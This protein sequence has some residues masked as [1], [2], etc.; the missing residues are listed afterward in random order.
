MLDS[1][2]ATSLT[3]PPTSIR[4]TSGRAPPSSGS[5]ILDAKTASV[6]LS[7]GV[8]QFG[9][10]PYRPRPSRTSSFCAA[11]ATASSM[12]ISVLAR[13]FYMNREQRCAIRGM[14][15]IRRGITGEHRRVGDL[16][17]TRGTRSVCIEGVTH[18]LARS[19]RIPGAVLLYLSIS[20][21]LRQPRQKFREL[22]LT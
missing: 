4:C 19:I 15:R 13:E 1:R 3:H 11:C 8:L 22:E 10:Q 7:A 14:Y 6:S 17:P 5:G 12:T 2:L 9:T 20:P 21:C 18:S 16:S